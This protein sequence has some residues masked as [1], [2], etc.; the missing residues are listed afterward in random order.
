MFVVGY[1]CFCVE[2]LRDSNVMTIPELF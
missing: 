1:T 2:P